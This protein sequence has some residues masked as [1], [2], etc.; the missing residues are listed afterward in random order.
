MTPRA[1]LLLMVFALL[2]LGAS[3]VSSYVHYNLLTKPEYSSF[4]DVSA[5]VSCTSAYTSR[6]GSF[7]GVPV[8][9]AGVVFFVFVLALVGAAGRPGSPASE[10]VPGYV[11]AMSTIGLAFALYLG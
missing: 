2:G 8:A 4:C 6:Y 7:M 11:F 10:N 1:R 3:S 9:I 5:T